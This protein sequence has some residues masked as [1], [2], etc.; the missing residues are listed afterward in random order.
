MGTS[1]ETPKKSLAQKGQGML[2]YALIMSFV[3]MVYLLVFSDGGFGGAIIGT[4]DNASETLVMA[5]EKSSSGDFGDGS[6]SGFVN[7]VL[8]S[9]SSSGSNSNSSTS[10]DAEESIFDEVIP[11]PSNVERLDWQMIID[12]I[13]GVNGAYATIMHSSTPDKAIIS[14]Y[15]LLWQISTMTADK[16]EYNDGRHETVGWNHF[17]GKME[18]LMKDHNFT[19]SYTR[20]SESNSETFSISR[21]NANEYKVNVTYTNSA[22]PSENV[23]FSIYAENNVMKFTSSNPSKQYSDLISKIYRGG[24]TYSGN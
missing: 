7:S 6:A 9:S 21:A 24:W 20:N 4:F 12:E 8:G 13:D 19:P 5:S 2:E 22:D 23:T 16:L 3:A 1:D 18:E 10:S 17:M 11:R 15:N 14:E